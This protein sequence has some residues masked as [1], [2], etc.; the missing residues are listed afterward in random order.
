MDNMNVVDLDQKDLKSFKR[1]FDIFDKDKSGKI[2]L[3]E[4]ELLITEFSQQSPSKD[5]VKQVDTTALK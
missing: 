2:N 5:E 3:R 4:L 1:A